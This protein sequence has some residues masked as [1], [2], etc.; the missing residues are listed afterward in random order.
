MVPDAIGTFLSKTWLTSDVIEAGIDILGYSVFHSYRDGHTHGGVA[1]YLTSDL[2]GVLSHTFSNGVVE[3]LL[4]KCKCIETLFVT[5]Y[6][7]PNSCCNL[8]EWSEA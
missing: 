2:G 8:S 4:V 5:V 3:T 1:F 6:R 7:P